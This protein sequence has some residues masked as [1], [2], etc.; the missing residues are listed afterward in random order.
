MLVP[1][2]R[3]RLR[4]TSTDYYFFV[5]VLIFIISVVSSWSKYSE[6]PRPLNVR[7]PENDFVLC[8]SFSA[9]ACCDPLRDGVRLVSLLVQVWI[10]VVN[11]AL[12]AFRLL[13]F[14]NLYQRVQFQRWVARSPQAVLP[15]RC[16]W[17]GRVPHSAS[18]HVLTSHTTA[19]W[20]CQ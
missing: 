5:V 19:R 6:C 18:S 14:A 3:V 13:Y 20:W 2:Q 7:G 9:A 1:Q 17:S 12:V 10:L 8:V 11:V 15:P 4:M 16:P